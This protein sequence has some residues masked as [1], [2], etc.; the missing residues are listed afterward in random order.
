MHNGHRFEF[1][2][3]PASNLRPSAGGVKLQISAPMPQR[4]HDIALA[5]VQQRHVVM[6]VGVIGMNPQSFAVMFQSK[7]LVA[8]LVVKIAQIKMRQRIA[9]VNFKR[10]L[11]NV[12]LPRPKRV[13]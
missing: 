9:R 5:L 4:T 6:R 2:Q 13:R 3:F 12:F 1:A 7:F 8:L 10:P 11:D